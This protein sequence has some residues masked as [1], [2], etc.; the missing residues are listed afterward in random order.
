MRNAS[1]EKELIL[2]DCRCKSTIALR[3]KDAPVEIQAAADRQEE[4]S[5]FSQAAHG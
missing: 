3:Y 2:F 5:S 1:G 4:S